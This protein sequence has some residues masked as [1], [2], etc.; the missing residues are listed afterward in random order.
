MR[1]NDDSRHGNGFRSVLAVRWRR[2]TG[3]GDAGYS[4]EAVVVI[5]MLVAAALIIVGAIVAK[6]VTKAESID[7][8]LGLTAQA[9]H[10]LV[11]LFG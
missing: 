8:G 11:G 10:A 1:H 3:H 9:V 5:S 7:F 6:A 4:T 2:L